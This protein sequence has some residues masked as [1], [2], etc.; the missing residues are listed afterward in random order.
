VYRSDAVTANQGI[1]SER[2]V[3][4]RL[5]GDVNPLILQPDWLRAHDLVDEADRKYALEKDK[6]RAIVTADFTGARF[7]WVVV[8]ATR[9]AC[10]LY[11]LPATETPDRIRDLAVG[12]FELLSHTPIESVSVTYFWHIALPAED[13]QALAERLA[14]PSA[15]AGLLDNPVLQ[16][17]E[18]SSERD[19]GETRIVVQPSHRS[20]YTTYID[21]ED[22]RE[23]PKGL[24]SARQAISALNDRWD[25]IHACAE[26]IMTTL[27]RHG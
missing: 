19:A 11:S 1:E 4:V 25:E 17:I 2:G 27:A 6:Q 5:G 24:D 14:P 8:E 22:T 18:H 20:E 13:W 26:K 7:P 10:R 16:S 12:I 23:V 21:V 15:L 3:S 9:E